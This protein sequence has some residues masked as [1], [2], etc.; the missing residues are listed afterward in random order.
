MTDLPADPVDRI[1]STGGFIDPLAEMEATAGQGDRD[2]FWRARSSLAAVRIVAR[3]RLVSPWATLGATLATVC[4]RTGPHVVLPPIVGGIASLNTFWAMVGSSGGG[5]DAATAVARELLWLDDTVPAHEVGTGQGIDSTYTVQ[6]KDGPVQFC[7][8]ALFTIS[9]IDTLAGHAKMS[10]STIM[11]TLRKVY[12]GSALGARYAEKE[13]RRPVRDHHYRAAVIAGVQPARAGV[14]LGDADGG[15]P[16][17]WLWMPTDDPG[18]AMWDASAFRMPERPGDLW[19]PQRRDL[20][21]WGELSQEEIDD[22]RSVALRARIEVKVC[23]SARR[24]VVDNRRARLAAGLLAP[25]DDLSGHALLT[26]LKVAALLAIF[27]GGR[28][29]ITEEDWQLS[30]VVMDVSD[31]TRAVCARA[32]ADNARRANV[33]RAV[34]AVE[35]DVIAANHTE[36]RVAAALARKLRREGGEWV[37]RA[38]LRRALSAPDRP[39]FDAAIERLVSAGQVEV[40]AVDTNSVGRQ[41]DSSRYRAI[42]G[43]S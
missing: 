24:A 41:I 28:A 9:E 17:R 32:L 33:A 3:E 36:K 12:S 37:R 21:A 6:T 13:K 5:K 8:A 38:D 4:S 40:E 1:L 25:A 20:E 35:R 23:E 22:G 42:G 10:G 19:Q 14:L 2:S 7:D 31:R 15:T 30:E 11:A 27:D 29:E 43:G 39:H 16:Q 26:R 18:A 34:Q